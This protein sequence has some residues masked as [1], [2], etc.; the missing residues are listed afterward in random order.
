MFDVIFEAH[1]RVGHGGEKKTKQ[2][3]D[4]KYGNIYVKLMKNFVSN[5]DTCQKKKA[6]PN[7]G[8]VVRPLTLCDLPTDET[9]KHCSR[10]KQLAEYVKSAA[11]YA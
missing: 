9:N 1:V 10:K 6:K 4:E 2:A 5:C 7:K 8:L 11:F 3:V